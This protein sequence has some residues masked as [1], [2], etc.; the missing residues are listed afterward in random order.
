MGTVE[1]ID[2][3]EWIYDEQ[4]GSV[5]IIIDNIKQV[6]DRAVIEKLFNLLYLTV[7][8]ADPTFCL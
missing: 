7:S 3:W 2:M 6:S 1:L 4:H 5:S 8:D